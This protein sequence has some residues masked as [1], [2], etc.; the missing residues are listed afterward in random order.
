[1]DKP[2]DGKE[3]VVASWISLATERKSCSIMDKPSDGKKEMIEFV[4]LSVCVRVKKKRG[5]G[6][7]GYLSG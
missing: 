2:S 3:R 6:A 4:C 7:R 1:M 5:G